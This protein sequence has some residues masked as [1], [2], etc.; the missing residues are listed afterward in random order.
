MTLRLCAGLFVLLAAG[1]AGEK[2]PPVGAAGNDNVEISA[3]PILDHEE[4]QKLLGSDLGG[5]IILVE[6]TVKPKTDKPLAVSLDDFTLISHKDGQ[7]SQ[8]FE[9]SQIAGNTAMVVKTTGDRSRGPSW[10]IGG[11]GI[12]GGT[13]SVHPTT[14]TA[15]MTTDD[16]KKDDPLLATLAAKILP[17]KQ[18]T[19]PV[20]G[21][22]YFPIDGKQKPKDLELY[23]KGPGGRFSMIFK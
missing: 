17:E 11:F 6:V 8:P 2:K 4:I 20:S 23:Y 10:G 5:S 22:L 15:T 7:K 18:T 19:E 1:Y 12:G 14:T 3:K 13:G 16:K 9:P 21:L